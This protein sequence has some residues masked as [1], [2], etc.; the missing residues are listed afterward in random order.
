MAATMLLLL[1]GVPQGLLDRADQA[2]AAYTACLFAN[3]RDA[4]AANLSVEQLE[5]RLSASCLDHER[6]VR[7]I[8]TKIFRLRDN[9]D[10]EGQARQLTGAARSMVIDSYRTLPEQQRALDEL[11]RIC[12]EVPDSCR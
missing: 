12:R 7:Q 2:N 1:A 11:A 5:R 6:A 3:A 9:P 8:G 10:P 4:H